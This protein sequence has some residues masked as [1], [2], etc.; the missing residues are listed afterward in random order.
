MCIYY[1][2]LNIDI[3]PS[4][5][6]QFVPYSTLS[7]N[8]STNTEFLKN[9]CIH[10][11]VKSVDVYS[12]HNISNVPSWRQPSHHNQEFCHFVLTY[13]N[14]R[15]RHKSPFF[16]DPFF[17]HENGYKMQFRVDANWDGHGHI[18]VYVYLMKGPMDNF[19]RW[20]KS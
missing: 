2:V 18:G 3:A 6:G 4:G 7:N 20:G 10:I 15:K 5:C 9:N 16:S 13:F 8:Q 14:K 17:T 19:L 1:R 12:S 11:K